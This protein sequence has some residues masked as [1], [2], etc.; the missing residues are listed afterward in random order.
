MMAIITIS[1]GSYMVM[2]PLIDELPEF[3]SIEAVKCNEYN[4]LSRA[5]NEA[6]QHHEVNLDLTRKAESAIV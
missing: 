6:L 5:Q 1:R 2:P 3:I 4:P